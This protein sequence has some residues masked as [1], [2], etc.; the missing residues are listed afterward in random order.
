MEDRFKKEAECFNTI[1]T[2]RNR[3]NQIPD[4]RVD[5][6]NDYFYNNIWRDSRFLLEEYNPICQW[7]IDSLKGVKAQ[8]VVDLGCGVGF[9]SLELARAG[10]NVTGLDLSEVSINIAKNYASKSK[11][12]LSLNY[13]CKNILDF[14][15]Y[16]ET[17][18]VSFGF[19]HHLPKEILKESLDKIYAKMQS[20][21][22]LLVVEPR[23]DYANLNMAALIYALRLSL[24][25]HFQHKDI[26][27][28]AN[29]NSDIHD[30]YRELGELDHEQSEMDNE[31]PSGFIVSAVK[32]RFGNIEL[33]YSTAFYDKIIGSIRAKDDD[34]GE[35][36]SLLKKLDNLIV[37]Y[38]SNFA[39]TVM[40]KAIKD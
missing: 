25:N 16:D 26:E 29:A 7:I 36:S 2:D 35:L 8:S 6:K 37:K 34:L 27:E 22:V 9:L 1:S 33:Q 38:N 12:S 28:N 3:N 17:S 39:R 20:R 15:Q 18:V 4:L 5:F 23:Y 19:M 13:V 32:E 30:I 24:P 14:D 11:E 21:S 40:I 31:S 10:F